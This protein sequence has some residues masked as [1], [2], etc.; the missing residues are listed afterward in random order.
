MG[1][2]GPTGPMGPWDQKVVIHFQF[3]N[4]YRPTWAP[5]AQGLGPISANMG[6]MGP[7]PWAHRFRI[8][9][10]S[11]ILYLYPV[12]LLASGLMD[13]LDD[14]IRAGGWVGGQAAAAVAAEPL[15]MG[16]QIKIWVQC[17]LIP[18]RGQ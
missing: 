15:A 10:F 3:M 7:G 2:L 16:Y 9:G 8:N 5:W 14:P 17:I 11:K 12:N 13:F 1:G 6:P 18:N 4:K